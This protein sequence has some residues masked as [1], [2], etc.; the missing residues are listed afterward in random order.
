LNNFRAGTTI[1]KEKLAEANLIS[2]AD[3]PVKILGNGDLEKKFKFEGIDKF[4]AS[5]KEKITSAGGEIIE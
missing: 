4:S 1:T 5:A 2:S 3:V